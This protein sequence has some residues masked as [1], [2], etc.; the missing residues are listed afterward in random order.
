MI[1]VSL[2]KLLLYKKLSKEYEK[3]RKCKTLKRMLTAII[4]YKRY[5]GV[6]IRK[7]E[8][9]NTRN[10]TKRRTIRFME[11][12]RALHGIAPKKLSNDL[13]EL[14]FNKLITRTVVDSKPITVEYA[15][16]E[17][18]KTLDNLIAEVI[19]WGLNHRKVIVEN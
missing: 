11:L 4:S 12:K 17:H 10:Y 2:K 3:N 1:C 5:Y 19:N 7:V 8:N 15:L 18:G 6:V 13:Q 14:E 9:T 16:T